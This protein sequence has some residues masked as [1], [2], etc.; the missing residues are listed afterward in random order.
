MGDGG[1]V[2]PGDSESVSDLLENLSGF[3]LPQGEPSTG[4]VTP[5]AKTIELLKG[6]SK[7]TRPGYMGLGP[8]V[9]QPELDPTTEFLSSGPL[10]L[11]ER[12]Q[13]VL[14]KLTQD[15]KIAKYGMRSDVSILDEIED[16]IGTAEEL[17]E[18]TLKKA[19]D[20]LGKA[21]PLLYSSMQSKAEDAPA[22]FTQ[23]SANSIP[24]EYQSSYGFGDTPPPIFEEPVDINDWYEANK[25]RDEFKF[26]GP[27]QSDY[28]VGGEFM[29]SLYQAAHDEAVT[30][31]NKSIKGVIGDTYKNEVWDPTI[32]RYDAS[33]KSYETKNAE[34][35]DNFNTFLREA[36]F[37]TVETSFTNEY[38]LSDVELNKRRLPFK[39][40]YGVTDRANVEWVDLFD[41]ETT[42]DSFVAQLRNEI[43]T[44]KDIVDEYKRLAEVEVAK[45]FGEE[46]TGSQIEY[47]RLTSL[48]DGEELT[49]E[50]IQLQMKLHGGVAIDNL[51]MQK[52]ALTEEEWGRSDSVKKGETYGEYLQLLEQRVFNDSVKDPQLMAL[53]KEIFGDEQQEG[54]VAIRPLLA[55]GIEVGKWTDRDDYW[56]QFALNTEMGWNDALRGL[57][58]FGAGVRRFITERSEISSGVFL[59]PEEKYQQKILDEQAVG[60]Q[61]RLEQAN[62]DLKKHVTQIAVSE[63]ILDEF[64]ESVFLNRN[65]LTELD[66][67]ALT[68]ANELAYRTEVAMPSY[69]SMPLTLVT[70]ALSIPAYL[71][72]GP[73]GGFAFQ[74]TLMGGVA[75]S[76]YYND[77]LNKDPR[78]EHLTENQK[79]WH[80]FSHGTA[81]FAGELAGNLILGKALGIGKYGGRWNLYNKFKGV[82]LKAPT[83]KFLDRSARGQF[84]KTVADMIIGTAH[85]AAVGYTTE[86]FEETI[87]G[88]W[89]KADERSAMGLDFDHWANWDAANHDGRIGGHMGVAFGVSINTAQNTAALYHRAMQSS[90]VS[91]GLRTDVFDKRSRLSILNQIGNDWGQGLTKEEWTEMRKIIKKMGITE[92]MSPQQHIGVYGKP[93]NKENVKRLNELMAKFENKQSTINDFI[94]EFG[95]KPENSAFLAALVIE[96]NLSKMNEALGTEVSKNSAGRLINQYGSFLPKEWESSYFGQEGAKL[97]PKERKA[98]QKQRRIHEGRLKMFRLM[99][100]NDLISTGFATS[101]LDTQEEA[102]NRDEK[103]LDLSEAFLL[104][105]EINEQTRGFLKESGLTDDVIDQLEN[106]LRE[107]PELEIVTHTT[108]DSMNKVGQD[109]E[110]LYIETERMGEGFV[111]PEVDPETGEVLATQKGKELHIYVGEDADISRVLTHEYGHLVFERFINGQPVLTEEAWGNQEKKEE[112]TY[113]EYVKGQKKNS[114]NFV[115]AMAQQIIEMKDPK[116]QQI[117]EFTLRAEGVGT[118][119]RSKQVI[120]KELINNFMGAIS[121][122]EF[123]RRDAD[124]NLVYNVQGVSFKNADG[125]FRTWGKKLLMDFGFTTNLDFSQEEDVIMMALKFSRKL[126]QQQ[127][128][129]SLGLTPREQAELAAAQRGLDILQRMED[130]GGEIREGDFIE[131]GGMAMPLE[132]ITET[133]SE[134]IAAQELMKGMGAM[135]QSGKL[136]SRRL[137]RSLAEQGKNFGYLRGKTITYTETVI[138]ATAQKGYTKDRIVERS[139]DI[140]DGFDF[141][142]QWAGLTGNGNN[143][144]RMTN[145]RYNNKEGKE[146]KIEKDKLP[147]PITRKDGSLIKISTPERASFRGYLQAKSGRDRE[148]VKILSEERAALSKEAYDLSVESDK[149]INLYT[150]FA[151]F[152]PTKVSVSDPQIDNIDNIRSEIEDLMI[153]KANIQALIDSDLTQEDLEAMVGRSQKISKLSHPEIFNMSGLRKAETFERKAERLNEEI[154][155]HGAPWQLLPKDS[156][157]YEQRIPDLRLASPEELEYASDRMDRLRDGEFLEGDLFDSSNDI[158]LASRILPG[159]KYDNTNPLFT[160]V[161]EENFSDFLNGS[162]ASGLLDDR[163]ALKRLLDNEEWVE[164]L[165]NVDRTKKGEAVI[166]LYDEEFVYGMAG[167]P[168]GNVQAAL[169]GKPISHTTTTR[170]SS[171]TIIENAKVAH[172][173]EKKYFLSLRL[174]SEQ[175]SLGNPRVFVITNKLILEYLNHEKTPESAKDFLRGAINKFFTNKPKKGREKKMSGFAEA[176]S[177]KLPRKTFGDQFSGLATGVEG[178]TV[179]MDSLTIDTNEG[180]INFITKLSLLSERDGAIDITKVTRAINFEDR[181]RFVSTIFAKK[182]GLSSLEGFPSVGEFLDAINQEEYKG[183]ETGST[184]SSTLVDPKEARPILSVSEFI[185]DTSPDLSKAV[186]YDSGVSGHVTTF[187]FK[188]P[189]AKEAFDK[190]HARQ[191]QSG[192]FLASRRLPGRIYA[193]GNSAW[194]QSE[195]TA[196]GAVLQRLAIKFQDKFSDVMLLQQDVEEFRGSKVPQSQDFEMAMDIMYGMVR[197]DLERLEAELDKINLAIEDG[198]LTAEQVSDYI[199]AKHAQERNEFIQRNRPEMESG[200]GMT[201]QEAEDI[202]NELES[203][204]MVATAKLIYDIVANTRQT[205]REGGLEKASTIETWEGMYKNYVP[206]SGRAVD[207]MDDTTNA[208]PTGGAGMAIYGTTTKAAKGRPSKTGVNLI[209]NVIM[210]NA[211]VKQ[212]A[213]KD[214]AMMSMYNLVKNNAN[215]KVWGVYSTKNPKMRINEK[216]EQVGMNAFEMKASRNMVP[217]RVNGEQHFIYFKKAEYADALNGMTG[218]KLNFVAKMMSGPM[219]LMRNA[220]T[221]Y[222]P[223]F[224]IGNFFRDTHGAI[225]NALAEAEREGGIMHGYGI[226][227]KK[228]TKDVI[229]GSFT[230]LKALL[231]EAAF[232]RDMTPEMKE[233]LLEWEAAGGRTGFSYSESINNVMENMRRAAQTKSGLRKGAEFVFSKPKQFF[234]YIAAVNEAF[235]NSIR[236]SAYIQARKAGVTKQRAAQLSKNITINFNKSGEFGP[237]L[238]S[239]YLFFNASVQGITRFGRTFQQLKSELPN[240]PDETKPWKTRI[241]SAQKLAAGSVL[242]SAM[243]TLINMAM[244]N[245]D[246]DDE[247]VYNKYPDYRK[248]RG[249][250]IMVDG[251]NS[252]FVPLGYGYNLF[253]NA[254]VML[255]EVSAGE[256]TWE[257]A[258]M[259]MGLSA[260]SSFSPIAFGHSG[261]LGKSALKG[262]LPTVL[263][264]PTDAFGF[265]ETYFGGQVY[266]EQY[267]WGAEVPESTLSFRSPDMVQEAAVALH[268][269]TG[270]TENLPGDI[271][272]NPDPYFYILQSYWGGAGDFVEK[273]ARMGRVGYEMGRKKYNRLAASRNTDEFV[274]N[275][276]TMPEEEKPVVRFSDAPILKTIYGGPSRFYDFDLFEENRQEVLQ[277]DAELRKSRETPD[278]VDFTGVQRLKTELGKAEKWL[279]NIRDNKKKARDIE[280]YIERGR[281][282]YELQEAERQIIMRFNAIYYE[283]RGQ[284]VDPKPQGIIPIN[285]IRKAIGTDE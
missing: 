266:R 132:D 3:G 12:A 171:S 32:A 273:S 34:S 256:R 160:E 221:Q 23:A 248:E 165:H 228:F 4:L 258:L 60:F 148:T 158:G 173:A 270:G 217:I 127:A 71:T 83:G 211:M 97:T 205:M 80:A 277:Y 78:Y 140:K 67:D 188:T 130:P 233:Y 94:K 210:Q 121:D 207:E 110:G 50:G 220:F 30:E 105:G 55:G 5:E 263:K 168:L 222:N 61:D 69:R 128:G 119:E 92:G 190:M 90:L 18:K 49:E 73:Y 106:I 194:E 98:K 193:Q 8:T 42:V 174:L 109:T 29:P 213:R 95:K 100:E 260:H 237:A 226:D 255:A 155:E 214:Q 142:Y 89:Q 91:R 225:Y 75:G 166:K 240:N 96:S 192:V 36:D 229:A 68:R 44:D 1:N 13:N 268:E 63:N 257:D 77:A 57:S 199:Y 151:D 54:V 219:S 261:T 245:R 103:G 249:F 126:Q 254:G 133:K 59:S 157:S 281:K 131:V 231:N 243:Q 84:G 179:T 242:F 275:L 122:G 134:E 232:D 118:T 43:K 279:E 138:G 31:Y 129:T 99:L 76:M 200:S 87:T 238:N 143:L 62:N 285:D 227:S 39:A 189:I 107:N 184:I 178:V 79:T 244:S 56:N 209:A 113:E 37:S 163:E 45:G 218:E 153:A 253:N 139:L 239:M 276:L 191:Q 265:N 40:D 259:F 2:D 74:S 204:E 172:R 182:M 116:I 162:I 175:N 81:E 206:L 33:S 169:E 236:L 108:M 58:M 22:K 149:K 66:A 70:H 267:P 271:E 176:M 14:N 111:T 145:V 150:N 123:I 280:D 224:F 115:N 186:A 215:E 196:Y 187:F 46:G 102:V 104:S 7:E 156:P 278:H 112:E 185:E 6:Y 10:S 38:N 177:A 161:T 64:G 51:I 144:E 9:I 252:M 170:E 21:D 230:T 269:M 141:V 137:G 124:G 216:G 203:P 136:A 16:E 195:A 246:D 284:H 235:E 35:N 85:A 272:I 52:I 152:N 88:Y 159:I 27:L 120:N 274:D 223:S 234:E 17:G 202:I 154:Q 183:V 241:S 47:S 147:Q 65:H 117:V 264:A 28:Y 24:E 93:E 53:S 48:Y 283:L 251:E 135:S 101:G 250:Q 247:L 198:G 164:S 201:N 180:L 26:K 167:G 197:T 82:D 212:R 20:K 114:E 181:G 41:N 15:Q 11:N 262:V 146:V 72:T 125:G 282:A 19:S 208:Y 86:R 25:D